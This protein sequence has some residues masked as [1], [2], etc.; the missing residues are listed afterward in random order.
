METQ[1]T[2]RQEQKKPT[3][4]ISLASIE[5]IEDQAKEWMS[6]EELHTQHKHSRNQ[7]LDYARQFYRAI[8]SELR[9]AQKD[10]PYCSDLVMLN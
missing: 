5:R 3:L 8:V 4:E 10:S 1:N 2:Q 6:S 9:K 7:Q